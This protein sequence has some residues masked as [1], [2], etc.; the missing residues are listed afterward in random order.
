VLTAI[1]SLVFSLADTTVVL[2]HREHDVT[3]DGTSEILRV[4]GTGRSVDSLDVT[5]FIVSGVDTVYRARLA[6]L[7]RTVGFDRGRH[8]VSAD[9]HRRRLAEFGGWFFD[10]GKFVS[11]AAFVDEVRGMASGRLAE[12]AAVIERDRPRSD[13]R[14]GAVI[15]EE[16][17]QAPVAVFTFSPGG[18][19][20]YAIAWSPSAQ[21][22]YRI[23]ECC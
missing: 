22:F 13:A 7:T 20:V 4:V 3:G 2:G 18:D 15:W 10:T 8:T 21:R 9:E 5:F 19:A 14:S 23:F 16:I 17:R 12:I 1:A 6:P 11:P